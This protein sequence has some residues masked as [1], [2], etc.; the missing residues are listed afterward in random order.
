MTSSTIPLPD[1]RLQRGLLG[2]ERLTFTVRAIWKKRRWHVALV[3]GGRLY[4]APRLA[5]AI[6]RA[7]RASG[8]Q[9][10]V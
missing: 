9:L 8:F 2:E 5:T 7:L 1:L 6:Q 4:D 10:S 3:E